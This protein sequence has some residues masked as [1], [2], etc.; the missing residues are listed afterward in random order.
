IKFW[1]YNPDE[2]IGKPILDLVRAKER[3]SVSDDFQVALAGAETQFINNFVRKDKSFVLMTGNLN[4]DQEH[5]VFYGTM[6][7][8]QES[9]MLDSVVG[10]FELN[11]RYLFMSSPSPMVIWDF[12]TGNFVECNK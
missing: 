8:A 1:N 11:F 7:E 12:E 10:D 2:L 9:E 6:K 5:R 3:K 4:W